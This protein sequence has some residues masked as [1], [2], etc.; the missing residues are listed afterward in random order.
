MQF[1]PAL[2]ER[3]QQHMLRYRGVCLSEQE[4]EAHL[5]S[6][7]QLYTSFSFSQTLGIGEWTAGARQ[8]F[9]TLRTQEKMTWF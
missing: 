9:M 3:Y 4:S 2:I 6:L 8:R 7:A 1:S 5:T